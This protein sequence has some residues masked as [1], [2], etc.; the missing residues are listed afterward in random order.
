MNE[1]VLVSISCLTYNHAP[2]IK[3]CLNGF[4]IQ[5]TNFKYEV[6]IHDDASNDG[7]KE[8][9]EE[10]QLKYPDI[11]F[12]IFQTENQFSKGHKGFNQKYN[13]PRARGKYI[14]L[15]EGD[16][17][18]TDP[19]KLQKQVDFLE[20]NLDCSLCF[21][22]S[23]SIR[24]NNIENF[25]IHKPKDIPNDKKF[26]VKD[27]ILG[28][29]GFM[30]TN[31]MVFHSKYILDLP[32][33]VDRAP[34]GDLPLMLILSS[35]GRIGLINEVMSVYR[36]MSSS[37]SW[38]V[39]MKNYSVK[40]YHHYSTLKMWTNFDKWSYFK[41]H[42]LI[43]KIKMINWYTYFKWIVKYRLLKIK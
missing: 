20:K 26:D 12:P 8:I 17:Y 39:K 11:F 43:N 15:C 36:V 3:D 30:A 29:G 24:D 9:I 37:T 35:K 5:K 38:S 22:A 23:R 41:Y 27:V 6:L 32:D 14:A 10:Y 40:K 42:S 19:L 1:E 31:S 28:G 25:I 16:D 13:Y 7:T 21:H 18:W 4:L 34:V 2:Y 33:W